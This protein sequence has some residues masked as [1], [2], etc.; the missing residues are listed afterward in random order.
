MP[1]LRSLLKVPYVWLLEGTGSPPP[2]DDIQAGME[3]LSP[4]ERA[5]VNAMIEAFRSQRGPALD[6]IERP[7]G[8]P[9][10]RRVR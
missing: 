9:K 4:A 10:Q 6:Q 8:Q 1:K 3:D 2:P 7:T 5:A